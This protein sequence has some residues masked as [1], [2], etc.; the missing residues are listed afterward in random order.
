MGYD[1]SVRVVGIRPPDT[2]WK[3]MKAIWDACLDAGIEVPSEVEEFFGGQGPH[4]EGI[5]VEIE[6][7]VCYNDD[8]FMTL[9]LRNGTEGNYYLIDLDSI[10]DNI[11]HLKV[12]LGQSY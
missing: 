7:E 12:W 5:V 6:K 2:K 1:A 8:E 11:T 4:Q 10:P 9:G 3:K